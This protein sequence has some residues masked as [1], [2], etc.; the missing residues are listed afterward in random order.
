LVT[1]TEENIAARSSRTGCLEKQF[2]LS[3]T[4]RLETAETAQ[5]GGSRYEH[6]GDQNKDNEMWQELRGKIL[7]VL[8]GTAEGKRP[9]GRTRRRKY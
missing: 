2:S 4:N 7:N 6:E 1:N 9:L 3:S 8:L 5:T